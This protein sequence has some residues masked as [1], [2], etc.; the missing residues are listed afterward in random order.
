MDLSELKDFQGGM[1]H[2]W[3]NARVKIV[4]KQISSF[5]RKSNKRAL[6][7]LDIGCGDAF[8]V[9]TLAHA[10]PEIEFFAVDINFTAEHLQD[11]RSTTGDKQI[12][13]FTSLDDI[14]VDSYFDFVLILDV[15]EHIE[16]DHEFMQSLHRHD[17]ISEKTD[18]LITVPAFQSLYSSHDDVLGH[19]RRYTNASLSSMLQV[20]GFKSKHL[21]YFFFSLL[22]LRL[23]QVA[24]E[25]LTSR[26][27]EEES[28]DLIHWNKGS[29][30]T[31]L[32]IS[33]LSIDYSIG[34]FFCKIGIKIPGLSNLC[35]CS[36]Q[37]S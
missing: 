12:S 18:F 3:E 15:I 35:I 7:I 4:R 16:D 24:E 17:F 32:V 36:M 28:S 22:P 9:S 25:K 23:L 2:P 14:T 37:P 20:S 8:V 29:L 5:V 34:W 33:V 1:R 11:I 31:N 26:K 21:S 10:F 6:K 13:F 19:F 27:K 30:A